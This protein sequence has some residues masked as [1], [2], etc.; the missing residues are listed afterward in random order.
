MLTRRHHTPIV[1]VRFRAALIAC[2]VCAAASARADEPA[3]QPP[4]STP[5]AQPPPQQPLQLSLPT[6]QPEKPK[7]AP[8]QDVP[9][10]QSPFELHLSV[11]L[12]LLGAGITFWTV[13]YLFLT[14]ELA[15]PH[16]DPCDS[17][18]VNVLDRQTLSVHMQWAR[19]TA[20]VMLYALPPIFFVARLFDYGITAWKGW[21]TDAVVVSEAVVWSGVVNEVERRLIRRPRPFMYTAGLYPDRRN[22]AEAELSYYSGHTS[23]AFAFVV[24]TSI[25]Y[26]LRHPHSP[27]RIP[28]WIGMITYATVQGVLRVLS[29][30]HFISDAV[31]G[32]LIGAAI[33]VAVPMLHRKKLG[34]DG[35]VLSTLRIL[36]SRLDDG[37]MLSLVGAF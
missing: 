4:P 15:G 18:K 33:G 1:P 11:E 6:P 36:P 14:D 35:K 10:T 7:K 5:P 19:T 30:D 25:A 17:S 13:P 37:A 23:A 24:A 29:G 3:P 2:A 8:A 32:S 22:N 16:C 26:T 20:D 27:W 9:K 34:P 31:S 21:L 12:P 28:L